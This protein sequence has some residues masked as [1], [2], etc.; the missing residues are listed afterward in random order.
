MKVV[1][2]LSS[3][4]WKLH[5]SDQIREI[6]QG[7]QLIL[8]IDISTVVFGRCIPEII[9]LVAHQAYKACI[10]NNHFMVVVESST[11]KVGSTDASRSIHAICWNEESQQLVSHTTGFPYVLSYDCRH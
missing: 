3:G 8:L 10:M 9:S 5:A 7:I 6:M 4:C 2:S 1:A 11:Y